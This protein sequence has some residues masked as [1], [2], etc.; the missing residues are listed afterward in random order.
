MIPRRD[1]NESKDEYA[2]RVFRDYER[3]VELVWDD[4]VGE[5]SALLGI[6]IEE[7]EELLNDN[8]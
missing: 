4:Y 5:L 1:E 7:A 2:R 3:H 8:S 6:S